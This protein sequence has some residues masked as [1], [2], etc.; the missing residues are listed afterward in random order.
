MGLNE[1]LGENVCIE[2][3]NGNKYFGILF[4]VDDSPKAF[5]WVTLKLK[6]GYNQMFADSE[7][8]R[9]EVLG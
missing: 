6:S 8:I 1:C 4:D 3:K 5:S 7:I 2:L 9:M